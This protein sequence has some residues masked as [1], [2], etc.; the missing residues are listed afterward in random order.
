MI[1]MD[2]FA[3]K[4]LRHEG[5]PRSSMGVPGDSW[6]LGAFVAILLQF[7]RFGNK[8]TRIPTI[9]KYITDNR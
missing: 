2:Y 4:T 3:T 1:M 8:L 7:Y 9:A 5:K 6:C